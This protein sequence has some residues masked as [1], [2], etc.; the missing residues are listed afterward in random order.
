MLRRRKLEDAM[1]GQVLRV[2]RRIEVDER[3]ETAPCPRN[4]TIKYRLAHPYTFNH[5]PRAETYEI[6][7]N[8]YELGMEV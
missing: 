3:A 6:Q 4:A 1:S 5:G 2:W 7:L 8:L